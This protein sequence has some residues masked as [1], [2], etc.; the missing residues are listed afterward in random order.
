M[1]WDVE[2]DLI[3][4]FCSAAEAFL[5]W[6]MFWEGFGVPADLFRRP[7][8]PAYGLRTWLCDGAPVGAEGWTARGE[9]WLTHR[10]FAMQCIRNFYEWLSHCESTRNDRPHRWLHADVIGSCLTYWAAVGNDTISQPLRVFI[11]TSFQRDVAIARKRC[12]SGHRA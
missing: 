4:R 3:A 9:Q 5:R 7:R 1:C 11:D 6:R 8:H 12:P 10:V 2:G